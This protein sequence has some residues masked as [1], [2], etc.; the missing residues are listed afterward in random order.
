MKRNFFILVSI[1]SLISCDL[2]AMVRVM[3]KRQSSGATSAKKTSTPS[4]SKSSRT[5]QM[6]ES[7]VNSPTVKAISSIA[8]EVY[9][10]PSKAVNYV[11]GKNTWKQKSFDARA[12]QAKSFVFGKPKKDIES[13]HLMEQG[14]F[15]KKQ[16][17]LEMNLLKDR[18]KLLIKKSE[19]QAQEVARLQRELDVA[20]KGSP[21]ET[22]KGSEGSSKLEF[23][24]AVQAKYKGLKEGDAAKIA[25]LIQEVKRLDI[26]NSG[27][28]VGPKAKGYAALKAKYFKDG[29]PEGVKQGEFIAIIASKGTGGVPSSGLPVNLMGQVGAGKKL[30][31]A[32]G[33]PGGKVPV[34]TKPKSEH[35]I[36]L[37]SAMA[38]RRDSG[39]GIVVEPGR[40]VKQERAQEVIPT[41]FTSSAEMNIFRNKVREK[42]VNA[43]RREIELGVEKQFKKKES[44]LREE[45]VSQNQ[46]SLSSLGKERFN[47]AVEA[48]VQKWKRDKLEI[49][50]ERNKKQIDD[51]G[52]R[53]A[54]EF[55]SRSTVKKQGVSTSARSKVSEAKMKESVVSTNAR[56][57]AT[58]AINKKVEAAFKRTESAWERD[59]KFENPHWQ[60][61]HGL[62]QMKAAKGK[63]LREMQDVARRL[64]ENKLAV[65]QAGIKARDAVRLEL[66]GHGSGAPKQQK[67]KQASIYS[68]ASRSGARTLR[69]DRRPSPRDFN[70]RS[71]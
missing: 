2:F 59:Y 28:L 22:S 15:A 62:Q 49:A 40:S 14:K 37:E 46:A 13:L 20:G 6:Y 17:E 48:N 61:T 42:A 53:A 29:L 19:Q 58:S 64:P 18:Q 25:E 10:A 31:V 30:N 27:E 34:A 7:I 70:F 60:T 39:T 67:Q 23:L 33:V 41:E 5:A 36:A 8:K 26:K 43:K 51:V 57:E 50:F 69:S 4:G 35:Q 54:R 9:H 38:K 21:K 16:R 44:Q 47:R 1:F 63:V 52:S 3:L 65:E 55:E 56:A 68:G 24:E 12:Q 45:A 71:Q 66:A 32:G 11:L